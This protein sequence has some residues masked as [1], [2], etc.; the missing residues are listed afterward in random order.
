MYKLPVLQIH[1]ED[2]PDILLSEFLHVLVLPVHS[3]HGDVKVL[4]SE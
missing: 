3:D 4:L 2:G 1:I